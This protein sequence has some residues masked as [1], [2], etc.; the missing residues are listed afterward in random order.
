MLLP[1][2]KVPILGPVIVTAIRKH[3]IRY[4][5]FSFYLNP[6]LSYPDIIPLSVPF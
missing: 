2:D 1:G 4:S 3:R 6:F 5:V